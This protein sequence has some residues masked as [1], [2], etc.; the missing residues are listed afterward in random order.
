MNNKNENQNFEDTIN[1]KKYISAITFNIYRIIIIIIVGL[2]AWL[3]W[4]TSVDRVYKVSSLV[5][6][7]VSYQRGQLEYDDL[8]FGGR[9]D[10]SL[11]ERM[12]LYK[13]RSNITKLVNELGL[14][15]YINSG[16]MILKE[17]KPLDID[18]F[19]A[20][21]SGTSPNKSF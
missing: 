21:I 3:Y 11:Q 19:S 7:D 10:T 12:I 8:L 2:A 20:S 17:N 13:S 5:Q 6:V 1:L 9:D 18:F 16:E 15:I 14:N 4:Y